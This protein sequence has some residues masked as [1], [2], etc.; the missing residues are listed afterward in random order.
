MQLFLSQIANCKPP[1][2]ILDVGGTAIYWENLFFSI[3]GINREDF[4]ITI[5]NI[6]K[7]WLKKG[8]VEKQAGNY[9][10]EVI[11]GRDMSRF[12][13]GEF[14]IVHSNSV[15]EHVG[16]F[17]EQKR[18]AYEVRRV[19]RQHFIQTPNF[20]FPIEPHFCTAFFHWLPKRVRIRLVQARKMGHLPRAHNEDDAKNIVDSAQLANYEDMRILFP[21]STIHREKFLGLT[22]SFIVMGQRY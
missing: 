20:Y 2:S 1:V 5:T 22:K 18:M 6:D 3:E 16:D 15:I 21:E 17:N 4:S 12:S 11:D 9:K 7:D 19:G 10:F 14:D 8:V 13:D